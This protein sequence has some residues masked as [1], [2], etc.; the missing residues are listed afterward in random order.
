MK[1]AKL[2][3]DALALMMTT[4]AQSP[5]YA[6]YA[7]PLINLLLAETKEADNMLRERAGL[8]ARSTTPAISSLEEELPCDP[9]LAAS[10]LPLG[11]CARLVMDDDDMSKVA[12]YQNQYVAAIGSL[13]ALRAPVADLYGGEA[14]L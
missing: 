1:G 11:L 2:L 8:A 12:Y 10:A 6:E 9:L 3:D 7:V 13:P 4:R 5:E 14:A